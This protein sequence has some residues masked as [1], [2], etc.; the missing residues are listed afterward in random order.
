MNTWTRDTAYLFW[1]LNQI[2][3]HSLQI[4]LVWHCHQATKR[5]LLPPQVNEVQQ[6]DIGCAAGSPSTSCMR[7]SGSQSA[8]QAATSLQAGSAS[9]TDTSISLLSGSQP[10]LKVDLGE[11]S[12]HSRGPMSST[13]LTSARGHSA[14]VDPLMITPAS[15]VTMQLSAGLPDNYVAV[16]TITDLAFGRPSSGMKSNYFCCSP[17]CVKWYSLIMSHVQPEPVSSTPVQENLGACLQGY[18]L[19]I[20]PDW[21]LFQP[22]RYELI[23]QGLAGYTVQITH[24]IVWPAY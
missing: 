22:E 14:S 5:Y 20:F 24:Y 13:F 1:K 4:L 16:T 18:A 23:S 10:G 11:D 21:I 15:D 3:D 9:T 6:L 7:N 17:S 8:M 12:V 19:F 2:S